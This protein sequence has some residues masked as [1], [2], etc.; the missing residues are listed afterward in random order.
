LTDVKDIENYF[1]QYIS[2][3]S[4]LEKKIAEALAI[5][6]KKVEADIATI[7]S[8]FD[9]G[10]YKGSGATAADL[11]ELVLGPV[12]QP[13]MEG[14]PPVKALPEF[15]AG[16]ALEFYHINNL[17]NPKCIA[18]FEG[19]FADVTTAIADLKNGDIKGA[20][21][22][23][24]AWVATVQPDLQKCEAAVLP[25]LKDIEDY[26]GQYINDRSK[27][28]KKVAEALALHHKKVED[29]LATIKEDFG[30]GDYMNAG[31]VVADLL[32]LVLGPVEKP[33]VFLQ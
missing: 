31:Y 6:H 11:L 29:D 23:L 1:G 19:D 2:D 33:A 28:E 4:K 12:E 16:F 30:S 13:S 15:I 8:D 10:D 21:A 5:H 22:S 14:L 27:L 18:M 3:R 26:F 25:E 17:T 32:E 7:K 24:T 20:I 9:S